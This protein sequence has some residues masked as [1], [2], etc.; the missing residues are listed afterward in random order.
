MDTTARLPA[1]GLL[2]AF[3]VAFGASRAW[4][5]LLA[6][7]PCAILDGPDGPLWMQARPAPGVRA[8]APDWLEGLGGPARVCMLDPGRLLH[9]IGVLDDPA[10]SPLVDT[11]WQAVGAGFGPALPGRWLPAAATDA[12]L[13]TPDA[14]LQAALWM[15]TDA[16]GPFVPLGTR[17]ASSRPG[18]FDLLRRGGWTCASPDRL[19][20]VDAQ[21][22]IGT[23]RLSHEDARSLGVGDLLFPDLV[24]FET[25]ETCRLSFGGHRVEGVLQTCGD[26]TGT[27]HAVSAAALSGAVCP[28]EDRTGTETIDL[29]V[30]VGRVRT[31]LLDL[32]GASAGAHFDASVSLPHAW[33]AWRG[34]HVAAAELVRSEVG[35]IL[36]VL[37]TGR[38]R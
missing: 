33:L 14:S 12:S 10:E 11:G 25:D 38:A 15:A 7:E 13:P 8:H 34:R 23:L 32:L 22:S 20:D 26:R 30:V 35:L 31:G 36:E 27:V 5:E 37:R 28:P 19:P 9:V 21:V 16:R 29:E 1:A 3:D 17:I 4:T 24:A 6:L 2:D 18:W